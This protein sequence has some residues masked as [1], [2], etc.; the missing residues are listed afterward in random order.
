LTN[1]P[2]WREIANA[3]VIRAVRVIVV[4]SASASAFIFLAQ[5]AVAPAAVHL[6]GA[7]ALATEFKQRATGFC[8][9]LNPPLLQEGMRAEEVRTILSCQQQ[10][11]GRRLPR[12]PALSAATIVALKPP[13]SSF[14]IA[15]AIFL[16]GCNTMM[17]T[18]AG[19]EG[20]TPALAR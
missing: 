16:S 20:G 12:L 17:R 2:W 9:P 19:E 5:D 4:V 10:R 1:L 15:V 13:P 7:T 11:L 14:I 6:A 3:G 8:V 18:S